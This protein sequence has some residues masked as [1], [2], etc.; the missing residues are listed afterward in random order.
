MLRL[1]P[2]LA[3][4]L[5]T[6]LA[7]CSDSAPTR[8]VESAP[9]APPALVDSTVVLVGAGNIA[10]CASPIDEATA[11]QLDGIGGTV[12]TTGNHA[13]EQGSVSNFARCYA[14]SWG[15]H[16]ARTRP[17]P[18][19]RDYAT[20]GAAGYFGFFG[21]AAGDPTRGYYAYSAGAWRVIVLNSNIAR[22]SASAQLAWLRAELAASTQFCTAAIWHHPRFT[23]ENGQAT[24]ASVRP[25]WDALYAGGA[26]LVV[27]GRDRAYE[28]FAP[29]RPDGTADATLGI[30]QFT[31]GSGG[32]SMLSRGARHPNSQSRN[33]LVNGVLKLTLRPEGYDWQFVPVVAGPYADSGSGSCHHGPGGPP[34]RAPIADAGGPYASTG[35]VTF[36]GSASS[37][38]DGD[39]PL[40]Y[41][42]DFGDSTSGTG[43]APN[44]T[45]ASSGTFTVRLT[46]T[47]ARGATSPVATTTATVTSPPPA[48]VVVVGAGNIARCSS[49][50]LPR[51]EATAR[52]IDSIPGTVMPLGDNVEN[53]TAADYANCYHPTWGRH[54]SRTRAVIGNHEYNTGSATASFDYFGD[55][56]G[57]RDLGYY[58]FDVGTWHVIVLNDNAPHV[59]FA[60]GSAQDQW[61]VADLAAN[62]M[63]CVLAVWHTPLNT[64]SNTAGSTRTSSRR[65]IWDRLHAAGA[66][67]ALNAQGHHYE[68]MLPMRP[69]GTIDEANGILQFNVGTGGESISVPTVAI[70]PASVVRGGD[71]GVLKLTLREN[72]YAW[73]FVPVPGA[74]FR[75]SGTGSCH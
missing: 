29:M 53:G 65:I 55:K 26:D 37:D 34:N 42:W 52:L 24:N 35:S 11:R 3:A 25:F 46:V 40:T 51:A 5:V 43:V 22:D 15:R 28:R 54:L 10:R 75:D 60:A 73:E 31:V 39:L 72:A 2:N 27:N 23:S 69:D 6:G 16:R 57:P 61:L 7:A 9:P 47:D 21:A 66:D 45:Y 13:Y 67:L 44:H 63:P 41:A 62:A 12:F 4:I 71:F 20:S 19:E 74:S 8:P 68:R 38:P 50:A 1:R 30:R 64:S 14:P 59:P 36:D 70:H 32:V 56:A 49:S 17:A 58:S 48:A 18:G 33:G